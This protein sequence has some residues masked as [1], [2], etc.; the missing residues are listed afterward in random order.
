MLCQHREFHH[1]PGS[2]RAVENLCGGVCA[3]QSQVCS[4]KLIILGGLCEVEGEV[5]LKL[6]KWTKKRITLK[7]HVVN[8]MPGEY[9][10]IIWCDLIN[11]L[12]GRIK[13]KKGWWNL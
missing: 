12:G 4:C 8:N 1:H 5:V 11:E 13:N 2:R 9:N 6:G 3:L 10:G 7:M